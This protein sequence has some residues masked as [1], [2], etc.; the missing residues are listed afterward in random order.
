M[1]WQ[2]HSENG[3]GVWDGDMILI[4]M[5]TGRISSSYAT[6]SSDLGFVWWDYIVEEVANSQILDCIPEPGIQMP[7][8]TYSIG[9]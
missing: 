3:F 4:G 8:L 9:K 2:G 6:S 7:K 5:Y 1:I